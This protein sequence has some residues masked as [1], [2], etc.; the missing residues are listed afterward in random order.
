MPSNSEEERS[1]K[2]DVAFSLLSRDVDLAQTLADELVPLNCFVF[3]QRQRELVG[4]NGVEAFAE[5]FRRDARLAVVLFRSG[6][7]E[8]EY[9]DLEAR[10]IQD[11]G[12]K[13][14]WQSPLLINLDKTPPPVWLPSRNVWLDLTRYPI[15]E[16]AGAI[17]LRA[18][19]LGAKERI[20][21]ASEFGSRLSQRRAAEEARYLHERSSSALEEVSTEVEQLFADLTGFVNSN[22]SSLERCDPFVIPTNTGLAIATRFGSAVIDWRHPY[23]N[24]LTDAGIYVKLFDGYVSVGDRRAGRTPTMLSETEYTPKFDEQKLWRWMPD[25]DSRHLTTVELREHILKECCR[26]YSNDNDKGQ[27]SHPML[28][29]TR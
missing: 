3:T 1:F 26:G 4:R 18:E 9:T 29:I 11:R 12:M 28:A 8:T 20:E 17:R 5:V 25:N 7:G 22:T 13:T 10:G 15:A 21:S 23:R 14:R 2:Y 27:L 19:E 16:A 24:S 6:Y